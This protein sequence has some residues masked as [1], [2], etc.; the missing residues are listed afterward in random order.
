[1]TKKTPNGLAFGESVVQAIEKAFQGG[2]L[3]KVASIANGPLTV[4]PTPNV[5]V[6][7]LPPP[8]PRS[9]PPSKVTQTSRPGHLP[10]PLDRPTAAETSESPARQPLQALNRK[11]PAPEVGPP[12]EPVR[13]RGENGVPTM[14]LIPASDETK[15]S[16]LSKKSSSQPILSSQSTPSSPPPP[17]PASLPPPQPGPPSSYEPQ[18]WHTAL[19]PNE[20]TAQEGDSVA[21]RVKEAAADVETVQDHRGNTQSFLEY[22]STQEDKVAVTAESQRPME[23]PAGIIVE[24]EKSVDESLVSPLPRIVSI[25][26]DDSRSVSEEIDELEDDSEAENRSPTGKRKSKSAPSK[27]S[28]KTTKRPRPTKV[29]KPRKPPSRPAPRA[30][31]ATKVSPRP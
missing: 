26:E 31:P 27:Q 15:P 14:V 20:S 16:S 28:A 19:Q 29:S 6:P 7:H 2:A 21:V 23:N 30:D 17:P 8:Q 4:L 3:A 18:T 5:T 12:R 24:L 9:K 10:S 25:R 22:A 11:V 13:S 1:M